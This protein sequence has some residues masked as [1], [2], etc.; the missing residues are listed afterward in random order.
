[1]GVHTVPSTPGFLLPCVWL[2]FSSYYYLP[3][4]CLQHK[5]G[6]DEVDNG[7]QVKHFRVARQRVHHVGDHFAFQ[8]GAER[9][10]YTPTIPRHHTYHSA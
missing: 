9:L 7:L 10:P 2:E 4:T 8:R 1:M 6:H 5:H 3:W